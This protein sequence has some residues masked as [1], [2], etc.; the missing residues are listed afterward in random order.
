MDYTAENLREM[1]YSAGVVRAVELLTKRG[2]K[3]DLDEIRH[4]RDSGDP[5]AIAVR[6]CRQPRQS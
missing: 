6:D 5:I 2:D 1:G 3:P 4:I